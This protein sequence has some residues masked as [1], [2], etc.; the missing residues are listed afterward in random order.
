MTGGRGIAILLAMKIRM[1]GLGLVALGVLIP[2]LFV[3]LPIRHGSDG[4]MGP[5]RIKALVFIPLAI[6][7][8]LTFV[9][10]G[11][12]ALEAFQA[13][14]K[15]R[16]QLAFVL[17]VIIGSGVLTG[18]GYWQIKTRWLRA[19]EPVILDASPKAPQLREIPQPDFARPATQ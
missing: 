12:P 10:G 14:P 2:L 1:A 3:Y 13:R 19:P 17:A 4:F 5:V 8:G 18:L 9:I 16:G 11:P 15:S 7:A 6:V